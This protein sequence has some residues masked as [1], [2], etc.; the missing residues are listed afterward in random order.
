[1]LH[2]A[3][4]IHDSNCLVCVPHRW[5]EASQ[6]ERKRLTPARCLRH[7]ACPA[8]SQ[9]GPGRRVQACLELLAPVDLCYDTLA[10]EAAGQEIG[11]PTQY[12]PVPECQ[13]AYTS[14]TLENSA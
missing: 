6:S 4:P 3:K 7:R 10:Y 12:T 11:A 13:S 5:L 14:K 9:G 2:G 8:L 1:M